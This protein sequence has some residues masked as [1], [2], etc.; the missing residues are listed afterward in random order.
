MKFSARLVIDAI[1]TLI[2][3]AVVVVPLLIAQQY[4]SQAKINPNGHQ[5]TASTTQH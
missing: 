2:A 1:C 3:I 4:Q 5:V